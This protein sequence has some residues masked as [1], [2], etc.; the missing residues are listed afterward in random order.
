MRE[1]QNTSADG[2]AALKCELAGEVLRSFG[3]LRF[4]ATGWSMLPAIFPGDTL[5]VDR[6]LPN[7]VQIGDVVLVGREGR[8]C[9]HRLISAVAD[10]ECPTWI[11]QGDSMSRPDRPVFAN[12]LLGRVGYLIRAGRLIEVSA[13]LDVVETLVAKIVRHSTHAARALV[14]LHQMVQTPEANLPCQE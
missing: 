12:E 14:Y 3:N 8:L 9:A 5:V 10:A 2:Q 1:A 4:T 13:K 6:V 11:T 7:N